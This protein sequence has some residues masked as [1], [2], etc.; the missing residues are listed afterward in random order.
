[1]TGAARIRG[2]RCERLLVCLLL[3]GLVGC[4][5]PTPGER[6]SQLKGVVVERGAGVID[7]DLSNTSLSDDDFSY[8]NAFCSNDPDYESIHTLNLANTPITDEFLNNMTRQ[9][10]SFVS[11]SGLQ[12]LILTGTNTSDE[13][14]QKYQALDTDCQIT[15]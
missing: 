14:I 3:M 7:L 8:V 10:G 9:Q 4:P 6:I 11:E 13:A 1:M 12:M 5:A 15:R 2:A